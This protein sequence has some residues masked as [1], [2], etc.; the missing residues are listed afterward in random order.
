MF[1]LVLA[2]TFYLNNFVFV[3]ERKRENKFKNAYTRKNQ[4][5]ASGYLNQNAL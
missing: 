4:N 1:T 2:F 3:I 5:H